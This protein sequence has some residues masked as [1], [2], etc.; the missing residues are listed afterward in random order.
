M[1][2]QK[3]NAQIANS[4][5]N[6]GLEKAKMRDLSGA[7][8]SLKDSL[9]FN[10]YQT[11]ARNLLGL[12]YYE[13]GE[14]SDALVQW[15]ISLNLQPEKNLADHYLDEIQR[16]PGQLEIES[17]NIKTFN[18]AL[19]HAQNGSDDLAIMQLARVV[20]AKPHFVKAHL[21]LALLYMGREDY[22]KAGRS[23]YK[24][25]QIDKSN[26]KALYYM[27][28]V[29]QN[30]GRAEAER[31]RMAKAFSHR[32]MQDDDVIMPPTYKENTGLSTVLHIVI[33]LVIGVAAF[34]FLVLPANEKALNEK[35]NQ[36]M[37]PYLQK[38]NNASQQY[39][40]LKNQ[41]D[42][43]DES[44]A[45]VQAQLD[46]LVNGN[47][48]V[49]VQYQ[50][51]IGVL[52]AYRAGDMIK[53]LCGRGFLPDHRR[54]RSGHC[55]RR[56]GGYD[57]QRVPGAGDQGNGAVERRQHVGGHGILPGQLKDQ[58]GQPGGHV[59]RGPPV[60]DRRGYGQ[61]QRH[62]RPGGRQLPRFRLCLQGSKRQRLLTPAAKDDIGMKRHY[63]R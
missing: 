62:V 3:R 46:E 39:E 7:A 19:W 44:A 43:L 8:Q 29:K 47:T 61:R 21:L 25:L 41:Y 53:I 16:K 28:I 60:P 52:Q 63:K 11:D 20:Q 10:K 4:Y 51:L 32:Q 23:L 54:G 40:T 55:K 48:S 45:K 34:F 26:P 22:T 33:G 24:I 35:H 37:I 36:E 12:I 57:G 13:S 5:Y 18:Q 38:L 31:K 14:V 6:L 2:I 49:M 1:D 17:Q 27:S 59:L 58:A 15:V 56:A 30:T 9:H 42:E 50:S